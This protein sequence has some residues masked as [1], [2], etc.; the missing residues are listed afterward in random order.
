VNAQVS[1]APC[2]SAW[3]DWTHYFGCLPLPAEACQCKLD[4]HPCNFSGGDPCTAECEPCETDECEMDYK[5]CLHNIALK[6][7]ACDKLYPDWTQWLVCL[8]KKSRALE[9]QCDLYSCEVF[10]KPA[11]C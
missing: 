6:R 2:W 5:S 10:K 8:L 11:Y 4:T 1:P 7:A 3:Y 9:P